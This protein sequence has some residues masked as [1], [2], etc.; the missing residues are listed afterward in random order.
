MKNKNLSC[1]IKESD[2][3]KNTEC[4]TGEN[5]YFYDVIAGKLYKEGRYF[6]D[7]VEGDDTHIVVK[8][9]NGNRYMTGQLITIQIAKTRRCW[10]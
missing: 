7:I 4:S 3:P 6:G 5:F 10:R 9:N 8:C 1:S 2:I